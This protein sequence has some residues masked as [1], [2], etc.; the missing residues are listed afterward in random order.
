M[1]KLF[2]IVLIM[3]LSLPITVWAVDDV[4]T[5][6]AQ[7]LPVVNTID[8]DVELIEEEQVDYKNPIDKKKIA[9]KFLMAM[10]AVA[11]SSFLIYFGLT[12]Y[13]RV[14]ENLLG[15]HSADGVET[16]LETPENLEDA[17]K[18]FLDK[19]NWS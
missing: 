17:V 10:G 5:E 19:T 8:D 3:M 1:N 12:A 6:D 16:S 11:G 2:S 14:R 9:K 18:T 13:N 4:L 7:A 15:S